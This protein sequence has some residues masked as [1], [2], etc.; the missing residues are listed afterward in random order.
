MEQNEETLWVV[1]CRP[2][3]F[4]IF[5]LFVTSPGCVYTRNGVIS[6]IGKHIRSDEALTGGGV[7]VGVDEAFYCGVVI[8]ALQIVEAGFVIVVVAAVTEGVEIGEGGAG[9]LFVDEVVAA[10]VEDAG[11]LAPCV[12]GVSGADFFFV[13]GDVTC[14]VFDGDGAE[15]FYDVAL[16]VQDVEVVG[17]RRAVVLR[18]FEGKRAALGIV[19]EHHDLSGVTFADLLPNDLAVQRPVLMHRP[20]DV[21]RRANSVCIVGIFARL[22]AGRDLRKLAAVL[23]RQAAVA[24]STGREAP[25]MP[26]TGNF[27]PKNHVLYNSKIISTN[28]LHMSRMDATSES[29]RITAKLSS[30]Y[31]CGS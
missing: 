1:F 28:E 23:P 31:F 30:I 7:A 21:L 14:G 29:R 3:A 20:V 25:E 8:S 19:G 12:V 10:A 15:D 26:L 9:G 22:T 13:A 6:T 17:V 16:L 11:Q 24:P 18:E 4:V 27:P 2:N 5:A